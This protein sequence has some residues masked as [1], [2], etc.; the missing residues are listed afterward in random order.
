MQYECNPFIA[1]DVRSRAHAG[2]QR[3]YSGGWAEGKRNQAYNSVYSWSEY[4][5]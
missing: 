1:V 2:A 4:D 5:I 3:E